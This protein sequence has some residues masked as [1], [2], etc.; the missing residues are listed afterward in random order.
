MIDRLLHS[1]GALLIQ[2]VV[3]PSTEV[4]RCYGFDCGHNDGGSP[5]L[6]WVKSRSVGEEGRWRSRL[7]LVGDRHHR[8]APEIE[9]GLVRFCP[10]ET[11]LPKALEHVLRACNGPRET[12]EMV[13]R[14]HAFLEVDVKVYPLRSSWTECDQKYDPK[15]QEPRTLFHRSSAPDLAGCQFTHSRGAFEVSNRRIRRE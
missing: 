1:C 13:H 15:N 14:V 12:R 5:R 2:N 9:G 6:C 3:G 7:G 4:A 11:L 8:L 10:P